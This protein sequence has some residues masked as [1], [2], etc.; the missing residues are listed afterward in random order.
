M[1]SNLKVASWLAELVV[2]HGPVVAR[3]RVL[4]QE[5]VDRGAQGDACGG[6]RCA[7]QVL[8]RDAQAD[9]RGTAQ[10]INRGTQAVARGA[11]R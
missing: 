9:A 7:S 8:D 4:V 3:A 10:V 5:V 11:A 6:A 1:S 2:D